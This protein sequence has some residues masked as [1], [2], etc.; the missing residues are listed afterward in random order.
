MREKRTGEDGDEEG[1]VQVAGR[2]LRLYSLRQRLLSARRSLSFGCGVG[3]VNGGFHD[4]AVAS[5]GQPRDAEDQG[6]PGAGNFRLEVC[7]G[8]QC[9]HLFQL[10]MGQFGLVPVCWIPVL[11]LAAGIDEPKTCRSEHHIPIPRVLQGSR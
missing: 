2:Q 4:T 6:F 8:K 11:E 3:A 7:W 9:W 10:E 5:R 1:E